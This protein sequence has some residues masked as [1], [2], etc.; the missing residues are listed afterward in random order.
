MWQYLK[1]VCTIFFY[2][3]YLLSHAYL[4]EIA[5]QSSY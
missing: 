4:Y 1:I 3:D 5:S 2:I